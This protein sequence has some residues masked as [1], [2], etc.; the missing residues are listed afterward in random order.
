MG[1]RRIDMGELDLAFTGVVLAMER[2]EAFKPLGRK[3]QGLRLLLRELRG[4]KTA[5][6]LLV[7]VSFALIVPNIV[8]AGLSKLFL[9]GILIRPSTSW[10]VPLLVGIAATPKVRPLLPGRPPIRLLSLQ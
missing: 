10:L 6:G 3:P 2:T 7:I 9:D 4:S 5:V 1:G 8:A